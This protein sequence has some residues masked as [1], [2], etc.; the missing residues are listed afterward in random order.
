MASIRKQLSVHLFVSVAVKADVRTYSKIA[1]VLKTREG[2]N[3]VGRY[4]I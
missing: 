4:P 1:D 2:E 3:G